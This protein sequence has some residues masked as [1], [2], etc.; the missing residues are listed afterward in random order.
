[1][2]ALSLREPG[3]KLT[4]QSGCLMLSTD[5]SESWSHGGRGSDPGPE[6]L[7]GE[8]SCQRPRSLTVLN[9]DSLSRIVPPEWDGEAGF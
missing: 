2:W 6:R 1:M 8:A 7:P 9:A 3:Q 5:T 4:C